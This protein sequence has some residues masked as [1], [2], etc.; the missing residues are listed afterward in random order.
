MTHLLSTTLII[1]SLLTVSNHLNAQPVDHSQI[2]SSE[3]FY[4]LFPGTIV[5]EDKELYLHTCQTIDAK[6]K[7]SF[8]HQKDKQRIFDLI[9]KYPQ[10]WVNLSANAKDENGQYLMSVAGIYEEY[11]NQTCHLID[12]LEKLAEE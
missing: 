3:V 7:L 4:D 2:E 1:F 10:F 11:L 5:Q 9:R 6:F 12:L 8:N